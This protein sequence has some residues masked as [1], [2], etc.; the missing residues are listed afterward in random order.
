MSTYR[1]SNKGSLI[2]VGTGIR[3]V[4]QLTMEAIAWMKKADRLLY[5]VGDRVAEATILQLNSSGAESL[6]PFYVE[7]KPR[8]DTYNEMVERILACVRA[9][10]L[11]CVAAYGHPGVFAYPFHVAIRQARAEGYG[12]RMLPA[13]SAEDCLFADLGIDPATYGCQSFEATD[14][15]LH[16]RVPDPSAALILWQIGAVGDPL[17]H[18]DGYNLSLLPLLVARLCQ[19]C[20]PDH[21]C[22]VYEAAIYP[23]IDPTIR[24]APIRSLTEM[25]LTW[26]ST[27]YI[28][29]SRP[30]SRDTYVLSRIGALLAT[31]AAQ[32]SSDRGSSEVER[33]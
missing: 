24:Q 18:R 11:T 28:P 6:L 33:K 23:D 7:G 14:F 17:Y 19:F 4:G 1:E 29:P 12:A 10:M 20:P 21:V 32:K 3:V 9:G 22:T 25:T 13:I 30:S 16:A 31:A 15:L 5:L 8:I 2:V 27:V 26:V